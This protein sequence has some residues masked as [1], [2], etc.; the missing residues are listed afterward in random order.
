MGREFI[1]V[2]N[3]KIES[4]L[5]EDSRIKKAS[6]TP[7]VFADGTNSAYSSISTNDSKSDK[8]DGFKIYSAEALKAATNRIRKSGK[9]S[10]R[11]R[12]SLARQLDPTG[13]GPISAWI[14][15]HAFKISPGTSAFQEYVLSKD[16][17]I[18]EVKLSVKNNSVL[19]K[20]DVLVTTL[21]DITSSVILTSYYPMEAVETIGFPA[22]KAYEGHVIKIIYH[23][24]GTSVVELK[25]NCL[26]ETRKD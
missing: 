22:I 5:L 24:R 19:D 11:T 13:E 16:V 21:N 26:L 9:I 14:G 18:H 17:N 8:F 4:K 10:N 12:S 3:D 7:I 2:E 1:I 15:T 20:M 23:N 6:A 25:A